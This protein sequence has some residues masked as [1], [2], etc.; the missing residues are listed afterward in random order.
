MKWMPRGRA[1]LHR[2]DVDMSIAAPQYDKF[3][4]QVV[5]DGKV[6]TF[7]SGGEFLVF[8]VRDHEVVPFWSSRS[9]LTTI[10]KAFPKYQPYD[11]TEMK[12]DEFV[13]WLPDL[14]DEGIC[15]GTNWS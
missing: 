7:T 14:E 10:Q 6:F 9:R 12:L 8:K 3:K 13:R 11:I 2:M 4:R 15:V 5:E 1:C